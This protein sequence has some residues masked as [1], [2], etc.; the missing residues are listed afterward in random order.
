MGIGKTMTVEQRDF[1]DLIRAY[2]NKES[3][4]PDS[5]TNWL[6]MVYYAEI[7]NCRGVLYYMC[8]RLPEEQRPGPMLFG[9]LKQ[10]YLADLAMHQI[11]E[12]N[13]QE[14][15][16]A[17]GQADI[18]VCVCKGFVTKN[19]YPIPE[20]REMGDVDA[21]VFP[22]QLYKAHE[23]MVELGA[24]AGEEKGY[25]W[26]YVRKG[27]RI[28]IHSNL[29]PEKSWNEVDY[30]AYF[31]DAMQ[32]TIETEAGCLELQP[33]YHFIFLMAHMAKH[34]YT[35]G[36]GLHMIT[37]IAM[38]I[39]QFDQTLDW[40]WIW[41]ELKT[42]HLAVLA[43]TMLQLSGEW[44]GISSQQITDRIDDALY[45]ELS[46]QI[47]EDGIFG[48]ASKEREARR[49]RQSM[50]AD[51]RAGIWVS[52]RALFRNLFP[53]RRFM[54]RYLEALK[55]HPY[56]LP[57]AWGKRWL[58]VLRTRRFEIKGALKAL[59]TSREEASKQYRLLKKLGMYEK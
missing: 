16:D 58:V 51:G 44:F 32:H 45:E 25:E 56:L 12:S 47:L 46:D 6:R 9:N 48:F 39:Q 30:G 31:E 53:N 4:Q 22:E 41:Q 19:Y 11:R 17:F 14:I 37:D 7:H 40:D 57:L 35:G 8:R 27:I 13:M 50:Q 5:H 15:F 2:L 18:P 20:L 33:E 38:F 42:L 3:Y 59:F 24:K 36:V 28:E 23:K 55:E 1:L 43:K 52:V 34:F 26:T 29:F 49:L 21:A 54:C 10:W